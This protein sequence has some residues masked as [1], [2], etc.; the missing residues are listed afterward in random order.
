MKE[1]LGS[2]YA[3]IFH[4]HALFLQDKAFVGPVER[5]IAHEA[6][7]AEWAVSQTTEDLVARF[8]SLPDENLARPRRRPRRRRRAS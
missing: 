5:R 8:R 3:G 4:A 1:R 2:E 7:N 6:A